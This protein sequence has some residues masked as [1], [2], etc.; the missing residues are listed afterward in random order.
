MDRTHPDPARRLAWRLLATALAVVAGWASVGE[1]LRWQG[2]QSALAQT[3]ERTG[4]I[5]QQPDLLRDLRRYVHPRQAEL[6]LGLALL[7]QELD[8][9]WL[10]PL[11]PEER[12]A[13][14][15]LGFERLDAAADL[16]AEVLLRQPGSW[17]AALIL[18]GSRYLAFSRRNDPRLRSRPELSEGLMLRA[19][20]LAPGRPEPA[21][22]LSAF[23]LSNW[24]RLPPSQRAQ[25][26]GILAAAFENPTSFDLLIGPWLRVAPSLDTALA[27]VPDEPPFW[28]RLQTVF[29]ERGD[30]E[31]YRDATE[32]LGDAVLRTAEERTRRAARQIARG[33]AREGRQ[34]L[35]AVLGELEPSVDAS[36][37]F[38]A[39]LGALPPGPLGDRQIGHLQGWLRWSLDLCVFSA[40]PLG[41]RTLERLA[42]LIPRLEP[43]AAAAAAAAAGDA[44]AAE[45]IERSAPAADGLAWDAGLLSA[46]ALAERGD[47]TGTAGA[48]RRRVARVSRP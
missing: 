28:R 8:R 1:Y 4:L 44:A 22:L 42:S 37:L 43:G 2:V 17:D 5:E 19:R 12:E 20:Q 27:V 21:R 32:R 36:E 35:L 40:C 29:R 18:G 33:G 16:A 6:R 14:L 47:G 3:A 24:S 31:R 38:A 25:A 30:L 48:D 23:Y 26:M 9:R 7:A 11:T 15:Q 45:R 41:P 10:E 13:Q 46:R 39:A 34:A